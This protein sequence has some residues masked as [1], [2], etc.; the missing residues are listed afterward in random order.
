[1]NE[2]NS[3]CSYCG[4]PFA[5][6]APWPR[7][8]AQCGRVSYVN[9]VPVAVTLVPVEAGLLVVRRGLEPER[10]RLALPGGYINLGETWQAAGAREVQEETGVCIDPA[11]IREFAVR[12]APDSTVLIFGLAAAM[13]RADLPAFTLDAETLDCL[14]L[15]QP[16][17]L[18]FP[19]HTAVVQDYFQGRRALASAASAAN[20]P[21]PARPKL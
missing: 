12:S 4:Q 14:V 10:G 6:A 11:R 16:E 19:L 3:H 15:D 9:P 18:A 8:C 7:T 21:S 2:R 20:T 1:M 17:E 13:R 5:P